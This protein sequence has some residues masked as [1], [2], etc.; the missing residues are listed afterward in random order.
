MHSESFGDL[1]GV[2]GASETVFMKG[3]H[4]WIVFNPA[5]C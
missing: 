3:A 5:S 2:P 4:A 1:G